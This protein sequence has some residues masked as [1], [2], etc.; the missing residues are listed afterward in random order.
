MLMMIITCCIALLYGCKRVSVT[1]TS[2]SI[3]VVV[4]K[5][6][7][8]F[9]HLY[10]LLRTFQASPLNSYPF[11]NDCG[12]LKNFKICKWKALPLLV[13]D[14]LLDIPKICSSTYQWFVARINQNLYSQSY[15]MVVA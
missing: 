7:L 9:I 14:L 12:F 13:K 5:L 11:L 6:P 8:Y 15:H 10:I 2:I 4:F 3:Y 1:V